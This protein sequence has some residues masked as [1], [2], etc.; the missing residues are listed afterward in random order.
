MTT[1]ALRRGYRARYRC[2]RRGCGRP[3]KPQASARRRRFGRLRLSLLTR[4]RLL[5]IAAWLA[6]DD[7][8]R[9]EEAHDAVRRLRALLHPALHLF[10]IELEPFGPFLRQQ[11]F[12]EAEPLDEAAVARRAAVSD[13][14][15][16]EWPLLG[17]GAGHAN[18]ERH[19]S[20]PFKLSDHF[21]FPRP[22]RPSNPGN[23]PP[24]GPGRPGMFGG[25]FGIVGDRPGIVGGNWPDGMFFASSAI[26]SGVGMPG[27]KPI[28]CAM[29]ASGP[30][31]APPIAFIM[32][33]MP[34]C[35]FKSLLMCSGVVPEPAAMRFLRL[36]LR[37]SGLRRSFGVI[38]SMIAICRLR[39][40]SSRPALAIWF[41]IL[42]M[43]G[44][45]PTSPP[46][47]PI[48]CICTSWSPVL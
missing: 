44:I 38:E 18:D 4:D 17:S 39:I 15:V 10:E 40:L 1:A 12:E 7:A 25:N 26:C 8:G 37:I 29:P 3:R 22:G 13:D 16:I 9:V 2:G 5:W 30:R 45:I 48:P 42:A 41:F 34:R 6:L 14:D 46:I 11:R 20:F 27:P 32:S 28:A 19:F 43:P 36:A 33:A 35:I 24:P 31:L 21:F 23:F 47:P